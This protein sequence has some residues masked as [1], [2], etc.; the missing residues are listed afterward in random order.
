M[1]KDDG[2]EKLLVHR[3]FFCGE[4]LSSSSSFFFQIFQS[5]SGD[6]VPSFIPPNA[7]TRPIIM[8]K[9]MTWRDPFLIFHNMERFTYRF[10]D[11][12]TSVEIQG[13]WKQ[14]WLLIRSWCG[15]YVSLTWSALHTFRERFQEDKTSV[16]IQG[17]GSRFGHYSNWIRSW[18]GYYF[19]FFFL[20]I[21]TYSL[22][23]LV[24]WLD[25]MHGG[26]IAI[27][28]RKDLRENALKETPDAK[29]GAE[30]TQAVLVGWP[31]VILT[32]K[33]W[34]SIETGYFSTM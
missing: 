29:V 32:R 5:Q 7:S 14:I 24:L 20:S 19:S 6:N 27:R 23:K 1:L 31:P 21:L 25:D 4:F 3:A 34:T 22:F 13:S 33:V 26:D 18:C 12:N 15:C 30:D 10:P 11:G 16:E 2:L 9:E 8:R 17:S 28:F